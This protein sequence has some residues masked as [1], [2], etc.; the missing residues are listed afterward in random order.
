MHYVLLTDDESGRSVVDSRVIDVD[1]RDGL[2]D[3]GR[4]N[5]G[6]DIMLNAA[7]D[8]DLHVTAIGVAT[9]VGTRRRAVEGK[10]SG[11]RR[12]IRLFADDEAIAKYLSG[13]GEIDRYSSVLVVDCGDSGMSMYTVDPATLCTGE[14]MR[15]RAISGRSIDEAIAR[16]VTRSEPDIADG[17]G[18]GPGLRDVIS[19]CRT[20]KEDP[21][22][23]AHSTQGQ[24]PHVAGVGKVDVTEGMVADAVAP[25]VARARRAVADALAV[26][27][28]RGADPEAVVLVG[29]LANIPA[30]RTIVTRHG[31]RAA[32]IPAMPELASAVGAARLAAARAGASRQTVIG[33]GITRGLLSPLPL[34]VVAALLGAVLMT[35]YAVGTTLAGREVPGPVEAPTVAEQ[36]SMDRSSAVGATTRSYRRL[37][38]QRRTQLSSRVPRTEPSWTDT[39]GWATIELPPPEASSTTTLRPAPPAD[40][41]VPTTT[42]VPP[43]LRP[44]TSAQAPGQSTTRPPSLTGEPSQ[45]GEPSSPEKPETPS[46]GS[47]EPSDPG[48][49]PSSGP[50]AGE[51]PSDSGSGNQISAPADAGPTAESTS[52][53]DQ[54]SGTEVPEPE[55]TSENP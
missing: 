41:G 28:K 35:L 13:T 48:S 3:V 43:P 26:A 32:V 50:T 14:A 29:G 44:E 36:P 52:G 7:G 49:D 22:Q 8:Q 30:V 11:T 38:E 25:M 24:I 9:P 34:A 12:Q 51:V 17:P 54:E 19:A 21:A 27:A 53:T 46:S 37:P 6:I 33:G 15:S 18:F 31:S 23:S 1:H 40:D 39:P 20:A 4:V 45:T 55:G 42:L 5:A 16:S 2:D 47:P 10:G